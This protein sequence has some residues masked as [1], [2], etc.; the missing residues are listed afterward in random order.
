MLRLSR[1]LILIALAPAALAFI[2]LQGVSRPRIAEKRVIPCDAQFGS[3]PWQGT[4]SAL[5]ELA[6]S[7][8]DAK[9]DVTVVLS[10]HFVRYALVPWSKELR[11]S[12]EDQAFARY[13]FA[14]IHGERSKN[15]EVRLSSDTTGA[16]RVASAIDAGLLQAIAAC[17]PA[18]GKARLA[19]IQPYLMSTFNRWRP[20]LKRDPTW[21]LLVEPERACLAY[22]ENGRCTAVRNIRGE[23]HG[24]DQWAELLDRE[25]HLVTGGAASGV[26]VH[27]PHGAKVSNARAG[28]WRFTGLLLHAL[29]GFVPM[30]D[31]GLAMALS[32]Q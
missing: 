25:H 6:A 23:F 31:A 9:A 10:N 17:F 18:G 2:R 12:T 3:E 30:D 8:N 5:A 26:F 14:K 13:C 22:L 4:V 28:S 29:E 15:W 16:A 27:A 32:A 19:S 24:P 1:D 21:F 20:L 11:R 7:L